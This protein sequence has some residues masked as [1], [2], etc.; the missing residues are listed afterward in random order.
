MPSKYSA[1]TKGGPDLNSLATVVQTEIQQSRRYQ[2]QSGTGDNERPIKYMLGEMDQYIPHDDGRSGVVSYDVADTIGW[3]MPDIMRLF[4][5]GD[6]VVDFQPASPEDEEHTEQASD[7]INHVFMNENRGY[8]VFWDAAHD[9]LALRNGIMKAYWDD[10][11][12]YVVRDL[13]G[14]N[15]EQYQGIVNHPQVEVLEHSETVAIIDAP[16]D[17]GPMPIPTFDVKIR[18]MTRQGRIVVEAIPPEE[19][20][21]DTRA[22][23][24]ED[25]RFHAHR[26]QATRS[27]LV[28]Q[29]FDRDKVDDIPTSTLLETDEE[30]LAREEEYEAAI[31]NPRT[32]KAME[33]VEVHECYMLYDHDDDGIAT[34]CQVIMAGGQDGRNI[35]H[36]EEWGDPIPFADLCPERVPHRFEG[37]SVYDQTHDVQEVKTVLLRQTM[38]N[39]YDAISPERVAIEGEIIDPDALLNPRYGEV[40]RV[41]T[42]IDAIRDLPKTFVAAE[43]F[44]MLEYWDKMAQKRT[45]VSPMSA[46]LDPETLQ[47]QSATQANIS[48]SQSHS[49]VELTGRNYKEGG[50][51]DLFR[52]MLKLAVNHQDMAT[53]LKLRNKWVTV[54]PSLWN[55]EM[56]AVINTGLGTGSRDRDLG[57]LFRVLELQKEIVGALGPDNPVVKPSQ[58]HNTLEK[59]V[60]GSG[61]QSADMFFTEVED[62]VMAQWWQQKQ[63]QE[64]AASQQP[65]PQT[66]AFIQVESMK[67]QLKDAEAKMKAA[68]E[69]ADMEHKG[70]L[71]AMKMES[72]A[73][74]LGV[75]HDFERE[76]LAAELNFQADQKEQDR[77]VQRENMAF[78]AQLEQLKLSAASDKQP[79]QSVMSDIDRLVA[80]IV[81]TAKTPRRVIYDD[82]GNVER[83]E[84]A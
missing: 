40:H 73:A 21:I 55:P 54:N 62:D 57:F 3:M 28:K 42:N 12:T 60:H 71:E 48:Q 35:L 78:T 47:N 19:Y 38:D 16:E 82:K 79:D 39:L 11:P 14:L 6:R 72:D 65:D 63:E 45:G 70:E 66:Q 22:R 25:A 76:K 5:A 46:V 67:A 80:T 75:T 18:Q 27:E 84:T 32:D 69:Q 2:R 10:D 36:W 8:F 51:K 37:R 74:E 77:A 30:H 56:D 33:T 44:G 24:V 34:W 4:F 64:Q 23:S 53:T 52:I 41:K 29:G 17:G 15:E 26:Y 50:M 59:I 1:T 7:Y 58:I 13:T 43:A 31:V 83:I 49:K 9:G 61:M 20:L 68:L 81:D